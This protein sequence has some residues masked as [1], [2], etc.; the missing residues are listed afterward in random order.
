MGE[1]GTE[2]IQS[3]VY[4]QLARTKEM[5]MKPCNSEE[6]H[7]EV[8]RLDDRVFVCCRKCGLLVGDNTREWPLEEGEREMWAILGSSGGIYGFASSCDKARHMQQNY[9]NIGNRKP[10]KY[11]VKFKRL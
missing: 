6:H 4:Q 2:L 9:W 1:L 5:I 10:I 3:A 11:L 8:Q 7:F